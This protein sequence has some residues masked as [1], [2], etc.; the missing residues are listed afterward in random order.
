M[1]TT[2]AVLLIMELYLLSSGLK[3][4]FFVDKQ[5]KWC[6]AQQYCK[7]YFHSLSTFVNYTEEQQFLANSSA[8]TSNAWVGL[9][10]KPEIGVWKWSGGIDAVQLS[11]DND[12][13]NNLITENC[14]FLYKDTKKLHDEKCREQLNFFCMTNFTLVLQNETWDGALEYCRTH[15][16]DLASLSTME[17]LASALL[18]STQ[19]ETEYVWTGLRF[20]AGDWFWVN[21][22]D[23]NYTAW[24]QNE[25]H[26]CPARDLRC[27]ALDKQTHL[28]TNRNCD[29]KF[30]FFCQ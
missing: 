19:A 9:Y 21:G 8:Q 26:Q 6:S 30:S 16:K 23:L 3:K 4:H 5:R 15:Y 14:G 20:L 2:L 24:D 22:D 10:K 17:R 28:W 7:T 11:W 12:Q 13:P 1:K 25:Q 18:E 29:E 27:G